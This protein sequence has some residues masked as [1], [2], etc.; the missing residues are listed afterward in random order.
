[1]VLRSSWRSSHFGLHFERLVS[2]VNLRPSS[3]FIP[4]S[5]SQ[6]AGLWQEPTGFC[7]RD[8][9]GKARLGSEH[10]DVPQCWKEKHQALVVNSP[11][12]R[13]FL[14]ELEA[15]DEYLVMGF[16]DWRLLYPGQ[17][18]EYAG[19]DSGRWWAEWNHWNR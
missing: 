6:E 5:S 8:E 14:A 7:G 2:L 13:Q 19:W 4:A 17:A 15:D 10:P 3:V 16:A 11:G 12:Y 9:G 1:V 18:E